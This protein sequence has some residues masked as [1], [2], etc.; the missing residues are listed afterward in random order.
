M[1]LMDTH[2]AVWAADDDSALGRHSRS[3]IRTARADGQLAV[4]AISAWE[5]ALLVSKG[6]LDLTASAAT[7]WRD[8]LASGVTE[9]PLTSEIAFVSVSLENLHSDPAD[10]F[11][12]ATAIVHDATLVTADKPL[13]RWRHSLK[14]QNAT[15]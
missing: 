10:R 13:L 15:K 4:S 2:T 12:A 6:R 8:L 5:I 1:I 3:V 11:I 9:L 7:L 14:R